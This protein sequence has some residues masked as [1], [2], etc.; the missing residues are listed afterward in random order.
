M[1]KWISA[2]S[3]QRDK[4][5]ICWPSPK[6]RCQSSNTYSRWIVLPDDVDFRSVTLFLSKEGQLTIKAS[7]DPAMLSDYVTITRETNKELT[8]KTNSNQ[9]GQSYL[10][11]N[12][13]KRANI[14]IFSLWWNN[15]LLY[16]FFLLSACFC[17]SKA[18]NYF[19]CKSYV[20]V[21]LRPHIGHKG[22]LHY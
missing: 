5:I 2:A 16:I 17:L 7:R 6:Y 4:V 3:N 14:L 15:Q 8:V 12:T 18:V 10:V 22:F 20:Q 19:W 21:I 9:K 11:M 13:V 1:P